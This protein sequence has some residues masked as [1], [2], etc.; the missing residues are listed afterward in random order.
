[1]DNLSCGNL[2][3]PPFSGRQI[4]RWFVQRA[5]PKMAECDSGER[6]R[7]SG[8]RRFLIGISPES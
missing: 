8:I 4:D 3:P 6:D 5:S 2:F 1:M 7:R